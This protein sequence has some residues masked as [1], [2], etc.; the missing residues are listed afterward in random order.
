MSRKC[1][2][3][4]QWEQALSLLDA[5]EAAEV[6]Q[7]IEN[8]QLTGEMPSGLQPRQQ[9]ILLLVVPLIDR[10]RRAAAA[11]RRRRERLG[12]AD[13]PVTEPETQQPP[14]PVAAE[15]VGRKSDDRPHSLHVQKPVVVPPSPGQFVEQTKR[16]R[17]N[18]RRKSTWRKR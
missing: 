4:E 18:S 15:V 10:R 8:Y 13:A 3:D 11:A 1:K 9:M 5:A 7:I 17:H 12:R 6:R 16:K 14:Q 2:F